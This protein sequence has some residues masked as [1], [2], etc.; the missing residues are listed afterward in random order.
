MMMWQHSAPSNQT[1]PTHQHN[2]QVE[3]SPSDPSELLEE[4]TLESQEEYLQEMAEE[5]AEEVVEEAAVEEE[6]SLLQ[7]QH[8]KHLLMEETSSLAT[9]RSSSQGIVQNPKHL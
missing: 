6:V 4:E 5:V 1:T 2:S 7:H 3:E 9:R 8:N